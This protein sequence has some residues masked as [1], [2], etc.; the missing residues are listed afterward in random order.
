MRFKHFN[1]NKKSLTAI[2]G[3]VGTIF[4]ARGY[5]SATEATALSGMLLAFATAFDPTHSGDK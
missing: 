4:I 2:L 3:G 1:F 5:L